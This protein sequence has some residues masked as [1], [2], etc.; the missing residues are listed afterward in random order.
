MKAMPW[1]ISSLAYL[2]ALSVTA[3]DD[4]TPNPEFPPAIVEL[5][6]ESDGN[7]LPGHIY[8]ANGPGPHPTVLMLHGFP[9]NEKNLDIAQELRRQG[10]NTLFFHYRGAW[11]A[12]GDYSILT[13]DDDT[14]AVVDYL[15]QPEQ[16]SA[17]RVD[18]GKISLLGHSLGGYTALAA[19]SQIEDLRCVGAMAPAN[20]GLW[21]LGMAVEDDN[22]LRLT[23][24][25]DSLFMLNNFGGAQL[26]EQL[27]GTPLQAL[28][29]RAFGPGLQNISVLFVVGEQD[30]V[31]PA[32]SMTLP[33]VEAYQ[34]LPGFKVESHLIPGD[35]SFSENRLQLTGLLL[36]WLQ[37]DCR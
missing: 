27:R 31:T 17:L 6:I 18:P 24:Y 8:L 35:H 26:L 19:G 16:A 2:V 14:A 10:F 28:D 13:L 12:E 15:R 1:L 7:R 25:A 5:A 29:T 30:D 33:V 34:K 9:G 22:A 23:A 36:K 4:P 11:G 3:A 20:P 37:R 21:Q 32:Q